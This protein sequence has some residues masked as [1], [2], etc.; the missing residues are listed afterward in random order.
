M[1][2]N[3]DTIELLIRT[4]RN[5][6]WMDLPSYGMTMYP[7]IK[8]G[9]ICRFVAFDPNKVKKGDVL[10]YHS[11]SGKLVA[12]RLICTYE[13]GNQINYMLKGDSNIF[14]DDPV[15]KDQLIGKLV[16]IDKEKKRIYMNDL[17][18][19]IWSFTMSTFPNVSKVV[20]I[21]LTIL[22]NL[23]TKLGISI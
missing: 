17:Q 3:N 21:Y 5:Y 18:S 10:L 7:F 13:K 9:N 19:I 22:S 4:I 11:T 15:S 14:I 6:G 8:K 23:K 16:T 1:Q 2:F 12:H 20:R